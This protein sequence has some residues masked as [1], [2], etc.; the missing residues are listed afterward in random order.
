MS[1]QEAAWYLLGQEMLEKSHEVIYIPKFYPEE[2]VH[3]RKTYKKSA[4]IDASSTDV[5]NLNIIQRYDG[6]AP[7]SED[8]CLAGF[9]RK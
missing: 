1:A 9:A 2:R 6:R 7:E 8:L 3:V 4:N 5:W